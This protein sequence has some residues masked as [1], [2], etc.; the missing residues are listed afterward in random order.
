MPGGDV[1]GPPPLPE[2][3]L[4]HSERNVE[5]VRNL[6]PSPLSSVIGRH[7]PFP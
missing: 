4:D 2:Q 6:Q 1:A 3:L 7:D 5:P